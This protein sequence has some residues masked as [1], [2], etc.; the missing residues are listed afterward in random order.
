[1]LFYNKIKNK[2]ICSFVCVF[3]LAFAYISIDSFADEDDD[4]FNELDNIQI[5]KSEEKNSQD[6]FETFNR[7]IFN[8]NSLLYD[9]VF[10]KI[11]NFYTENIPLAVRWSLKNYIQ[12]YSN[13]PRS[14]IYSVLDFDLEGIVVSFW[15]FTINTLFGFFGGDDV[16][17]LSNLRPYNKTVQNLMTF[18][19]IPRGPFLM[20]PLFGPSTVSGVIGKTIELVFT[21]YF[22][23]HYLVGN[24]A[25][26]FSWQY[27]INPFYI[28]FHK[29]GNL[30]WIWLSW[31]LWDYLYQ[32]DGVVSDASF[33]QDSLDPYLTFKE[34]Y[35]TSLEKDEE[36]YKEMRF[37]G[38]TT[39]TNVCDYE[40]MIELPEEC[41][42]DPKEYGI[43]VSGFGEISF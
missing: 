26:I 15:R 8:F 20:L 32:F 14:M 5:S 11:N 2:K 29:E 34:K 3:L 6:P 25:T 1:M 28:P 9:N 30:Q 10:I 22:F 7:K 4:I 42:E 31:T 43:G 18:Y 40:G 17:S 16:A 12:N 41:Y 21:N 27:S 37:E 33:A 13:E 39:R 23:M 35:L 38:T 19:H 24:V 36:K